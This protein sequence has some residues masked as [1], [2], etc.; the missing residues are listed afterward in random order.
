MDQGIPGYGVPGYG[1]NESSVNA[2]G[3]YG[4]ADDGYGFTGSVSEP[5]NWQLILPSSARKLLVLFIV[6]GALMQGAND[7]RNSINFT[8]H[9]QTNSA[10]D[11]VNTAYNT[12][13]VKA[14]AWNSVLKACD[15]NITCASG[16]DAKAAIYFTN[17]A[18]TLK[19]IPMPSDAANVAES[20]LYTD[21]T[22]I[23]AAFTQLSQATTSAEYEQTYAS[24]GLAQQLSRLDQDTATLDTTLNQ[25]R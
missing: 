20:Q 12:L 8:S 14:H 15:A 18:T 25:A 13:L 22:M 23:S 1:T 9:I 10:I 3:G 2:L 19:A 7:I 24:T 11:Q 17:F 5:V 21:A 16:P 6:L 4:F